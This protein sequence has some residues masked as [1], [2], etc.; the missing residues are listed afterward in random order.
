MSITGN[1]ITSSS[2]SS[3]PIN[4][5][6]ILADCQTYL[7]HYIPLDALQRWAVAS[8][9]TADKNEGIVSGLIAQVDAIRSKFLSDSEAYVIGVNYI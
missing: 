9:E 6:S 4:L 7:A 5:V 8:G 1:V 2:S 3:D